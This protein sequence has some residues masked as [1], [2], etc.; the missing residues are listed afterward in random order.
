MTRITGRRVW[1]FH[2]KYV[3]H[4]R[5]GACNGYAAVVIRL[6]ANQTRAE[7]RLVIS[8]GPKE[9]EPSNS[10]NTGFP[11]L[12]TISIFLAEVRL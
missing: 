9:P 11:S 2:L 3:I 8:Q 7:E 12:I 1:P 4:L 6:L 5:S 10:K